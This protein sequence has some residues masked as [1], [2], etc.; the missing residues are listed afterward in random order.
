[1]NLIFSIN[2]KC[3]PFLFSCV[4]SI[5]ENGGYEHYHAY[6]L[7]SDLE[8]ESQESIMNFFSEIDWHF[9]TVPKEMFEGF[10]VTKRYP[11]QIYYRLAAPLL[12]PK[13]LER[14]LYLDVDTIV[15]HPLREL[16]E[17]DFED[18]WL[19]ASTHTK[20]FLT[21]F[22]Q[23]RLEIPTEDG[24]PYVNTGVLLMNL[25]ELRKVTNIDEIRNIAKEKKNRLWLPDQD[26][27]TCLYG[28]KTKLIDPLIYNINDRVICIHNTSNNEKIDEEWVKENAVIVHYFGKNK[29][30]RVGYEGVLGECYY[31][32]AVKLKDRLDQ[33]SSQQSR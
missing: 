15:I 32:I 10:P 2:K 3:I 13:E 21:W 27:L 11:E 16:Y 1:M 18:S 23:V 26:I 24:V 19:M 4:C 12:L 8:E 31:E 29:P 30:W 17:S 5:L 22:N 20:S 33:Y 28:K 25:N 7:H 9:I 14:A 6:V